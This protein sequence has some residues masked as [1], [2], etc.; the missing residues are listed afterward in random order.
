M[1][2]RATSDAD[3]RLRVLNII[4]RLS[5]GGASMQAAMIA[6]R[7]DRDRFQVALACGSVPENEDSM[8]PMIAAYEPDL[9]DIQGMARRVSPRDDLRAAWHLVKLIREFR[10]DVVH[11]HTAKAGFLGRLAAHTIHPRPVVV[12]SFHG[13]VL[14]GYFGRVTSAFFRILERLAAKF[15]DRLVVPSQATADDLVRLRIAPVW[16]ISV[17]RL[18]LELEQFTNTRADEVQALRDSLL[19]NSEV[20]CLFV[21]RL[22][23]I[24][25]AD[26]L[27][28]AIA[29]CRRQGR[30]V[31]LVIAGDGE[32][33][34]ELEALAEA[35]GVSSSVTFLGT[36]ADVANLAA[37]ADIAVLSSDNEGTPVALIEA[38]AAGRPSVTTAAGGVAEVVTDQSGIVVPT[39]DHQ[40]LADGI[41]A[42]AK[43]PERRC[44][45]GGH[46]R[47]HALKNFA[48]DRLLCETGQ[49][50]EELA[51]RR[52]RRR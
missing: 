47:E 35:M 20:L 44:V 33:R 15:S 38:S 5:V 21:G 52:R 41:I 45:M 8:L 17:I 48:A 50:Y 13:H 27:I 18:G 1:A 3:R 32:L 26:L 23:P 37:A 7:L 51:S 10:P 31:A 9:I 30:D 2:D 11:T 42:L 16:K 29:E 46:A 6:G 19:G 24:K 39:G 12:H 22:V 43:D 14:E 49:L 34:G 40:A 36:R 4:A 28:E 25:R